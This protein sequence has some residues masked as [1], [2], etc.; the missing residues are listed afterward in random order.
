MAKTDERIQGATEI[1]AATQL[2][3]KQRYNARMKMIDEYLSTKR[4][5]T[6]VWDENDTLDFI[7]DFNNLDETAGSV[8]AHRTAVQCSYR[9]NKKESPN[10]EWH[11]PRLSDFKG[12][13]TPVRELVAEAKAEKVY[14]TAVGE[15]IDRYRMECHFSY[16]DL[17][18]KA[19]FTK[20]TILDHVNKGAQPRLSTLLTY[21]AVFTNQLGYEVTVEDLLKE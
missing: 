14:L 4:P 13:A 20:K 3:N 16:D 5:P 21:A 15:N 8:A 1:P 10:V 9:R 2:A 19:D 17:A 7:V 6:D 11:P 18:L 12:A